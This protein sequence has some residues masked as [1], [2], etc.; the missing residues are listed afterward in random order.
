MSKTNI[1]GRMQKAVEAKDKFAA[2]DQAMAEGA[3]APPHAAPVPPVAE[4]EATP[5]PKAVRPSRTTRK[6]PR[7]ESVIIR[8]TFSMPPDESARIDQARMRAA[9]LGVI[10]NRSEVVRAGIAALALLDEDQLAE[11]AGNV[12]KIKTGRPR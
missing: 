10:L 9:R 2:A 3:L 6:Q 8:E 4:P 5:A 12:E 7:G 11:V 1:L